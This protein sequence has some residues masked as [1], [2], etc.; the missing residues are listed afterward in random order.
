MLDSEERAQ[1]LFL[2]KVEVKVVDQALI[3][4]KFKL[5]HPSLPL[6][7]SLLLHFRNPSMKLQPRI[8]LAF[9]TRQLLGKKI[10]LHRWTLMPLHSGEMASKA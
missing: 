6:N 1:D 7:A 3:T 2:G 9:W 4:K 10:T 5:R 8:F